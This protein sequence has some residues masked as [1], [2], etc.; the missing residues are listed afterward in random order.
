MKKGRVPPSTKARWQLKL[1]I[2]LWLKSIYPIDTVVVENIK[3]RTRKGKNKR[4][5]NVSFSPLQNG[6]TWFYNSIKDLKLNLE[7]REGHQTKELR[8]KMGLIKSKEKMSD[9]FDSHCIDSWVL[10]NDITG[11]HDKPDNKNILFIKRILFRRRQLHRLQ[12][13]KNG[14]RQ[15]NGG[16]ISLGFKRGSIVKHKKYGITYVG[17]SYKNRISLHDL[18]NGKR[19][20]LN[21]KPLDCKFLSYN[22]YR[23]LT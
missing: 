21:I 5:W 8:D 2:I 3:A 20:S 18:S 12:F 10:A 9:S 4:K 7:T 11:G 22:Y 23:F 15:R 19:L 1:N 17:G 13:S 14:L 16:T 6:K